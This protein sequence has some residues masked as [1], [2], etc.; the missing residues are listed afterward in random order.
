ME[1]LCHFPI[2]TSC[3]SNLFSIEL[4]ILM[5]C[6]VMSHQVVVPRELSITE[7]AFIAPLFR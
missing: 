7:F 3:L 6:C 5:F 2:Q 1:V 4:H